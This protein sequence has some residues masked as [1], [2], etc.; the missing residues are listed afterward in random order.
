M[1]RS[2]A[3]DQDGYC[4]RC[5]QPRARTGTEISCFLV[6][7]SIF[8]QYDFHKVFEI[9]KNGCCPYVWNEQ[10]YK[11]LHKSHLWCLFT[12]SSAVTLQSVNNSHVSLCQNKRNTVQNSQ[13]AQYD[14]VLRGGFLSTFVACCGGQT[15]NVPVGAHSAADFKRH[16][17]HTHFRRHVIDSRWLKPVAIRFHSIASCR[18]MLAQVGI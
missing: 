10:A 13:M 3:L 1:N 4:N 11:N 6:P 12:H 17:F 2:F 5:R 7:K 15:N 16:Q 9:H 8:H 14:R 18:Y